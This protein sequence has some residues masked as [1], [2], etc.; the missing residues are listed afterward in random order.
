[1][2]TSGSEKEKVDF[3]VMVQNKDEDFANAITVGDDVQSVLRKKT[4][5][6]EKC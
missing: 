1:M 5:E 3:T 2:F 6:L 4:A